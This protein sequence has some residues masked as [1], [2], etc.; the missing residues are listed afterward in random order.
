MQNTHAGTRSPLGPTIMPD[1]ILV[2][3][4]R[5]MG[6]SISRA[7]LESL[8]EDKPKFALSMFS[9]ENDNFLGGGEDKSEEYD[10]YELFESGDPQ[11]LLDVNSCSL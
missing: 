1:G 7:D 11:L 5:S 6:R 2:V 8:E 9:I 4:E 10:K 3:E